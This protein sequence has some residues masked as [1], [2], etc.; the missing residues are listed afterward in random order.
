MILGS[1]IN[2]KSQDKGDLTKGPF[3]V[4]LFLVFNQMLNNFLRHPVDIFT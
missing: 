4:S 2:L 1:K 3:S